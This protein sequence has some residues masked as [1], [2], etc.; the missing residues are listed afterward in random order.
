MAIWS[1]N[2]NIIVIKNGR[3]MGIALTKKLNSEFIQKIFID[4][5]LYSR[6]CRYHVIQ[7]SVLYKHFRSFWPQK[8][9]NLFAERNY[10]LN[11]SDDSSHLYFVFR[12]SLRLHS[13]LL[14]F[15][16]QPRQCHS[17]KP[18]LTPSEKSGCSRSAL[19]WHFPY[20]WCPFMVT[21]G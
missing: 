18:F 15:G 13:F 12:C 2:V 21:D 4:S 19:P 11:S 8:V 14:I 9:Y 20:H 17:Q 10:I 6:Y 16:Q 3:R 7:I 5:Q 1:D